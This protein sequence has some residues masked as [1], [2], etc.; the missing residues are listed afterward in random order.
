MIPHELRI[1][2]MGWQT[3]FDQVVGELLVVNDLPLL[4]LLQNV[5][6]HQRACWKRGVQQ[7]FINLAS[8]RPIC[9]CILP[10][11]RSSHSCP[12]V[13]N[14]GSM[15]FS[16]NSTHAVSPTALQEQF[17]PRNYQSAKAT[18]LLTT[19]TIPGASRVDQVSIDQGNLEP[20]AVYIARIMR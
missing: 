4:L 5:L 3:S 15:P 19:Q 11:R 10:I 18:A 9:F 17:H 6:R 2:Q 8:D 14:G 12:R 16:T 7:C 1:N 20:F 13:T